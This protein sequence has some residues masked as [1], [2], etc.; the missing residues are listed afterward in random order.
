MGL[1]LRVGIRGI[2]EK[3]CLVDKKQKKKIF[4]LLNRNRWQKLILL[5]PVL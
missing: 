1:P 2:E 4:D 3:F 5:N